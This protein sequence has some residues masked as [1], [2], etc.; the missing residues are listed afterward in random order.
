MDIEGASIFAYPVKDPERYG[1]VEFDEN[2]KALV[3]KKNLRS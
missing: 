1:V 3:L 2:N